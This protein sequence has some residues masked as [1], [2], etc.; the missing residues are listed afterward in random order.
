MDESWLDTPSPQFVMPRSKNFTSRA[1]LHVTSNA[2]VNSDQGPHQHDPGP[3]ARRIPR[4]GPGPRWQ[5]ARPFPCTKVTI[6]ADPQIVQARIVGRS[7]VIPYFAM[8]PIALAALGRAALFMVTPTDALHSAR[9]AGCLCEIAASTTNQGGLLQRVP[10]PCMQWRERTVI[11]SPAVG[12]Q[13]KH[14]RT[15]AAKAVAGAHLHPQGTT[16]LV[17]QLR[18]F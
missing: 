12:R 5:A 10:L 1:A 6:P 3:A 8:W 11:G 18:A 7:P 4:G 14:T 16:R 17:D 9:D 15:T 13:R 2:P